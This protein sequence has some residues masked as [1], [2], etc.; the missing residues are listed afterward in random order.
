[1]NAPV[2]KSTVLIEDL[3]QFVVLLTDW[4]E[5]KV[6]IL[7][8]MMEIPEGSEATF[9]DQEPKVLTGDYREG[10]VMGLSLALIELGSLPFISEDAKREDEQTH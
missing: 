4:H 6:K 9:G 10:F 7:E 1:M 3:D 8:K 5:H 2:A